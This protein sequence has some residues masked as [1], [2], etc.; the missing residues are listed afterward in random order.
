MS[1]CSERSSSLKPQCIANELSNRLLAPIWNTLLQKKIGWG[2]ASLRPYI[3]QVS[4]A[5]L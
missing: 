5:V 4:S 3:Y 1:M 2:A